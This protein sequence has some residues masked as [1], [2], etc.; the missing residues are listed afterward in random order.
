M[1]IGLIAATHLLKKLN[2][3]SPR[4]LKVRAVVDSFAGIERATTDLM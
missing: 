3:D 2:P 4:I 1:V